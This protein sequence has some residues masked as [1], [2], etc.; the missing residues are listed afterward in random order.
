MVVVGVALQIT[1]NIK[2]VP[3]RWPS[4][5]RPCQGALMAGVRP[6]EDVAQAHKDKND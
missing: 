6:I 5:E 2:S 1:K 3:G 4:A